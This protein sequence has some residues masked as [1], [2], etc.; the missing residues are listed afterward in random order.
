MQVKKA[1]FAELVDG[2]NKAATFFGNM[3]HGSYP[4][5]KVICV[6]CDVNSEAA[7]VS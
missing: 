3:L 2:Y 5:W 7:V 4:R 6:W 1:D